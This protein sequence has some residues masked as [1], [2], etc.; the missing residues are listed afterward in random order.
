MEN[1]VSRLMFGI[2][3]AGLDVWT[4][5]S[6]AIMSLDIT[7]NEQFYLL[8]TDGKYL[9]TGHVFLHKTGHDDFN[10]W[11]DGGPDFVLVSGTDPASLLV[12]TVSHF[13]TH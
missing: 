8:I 10:L 13:Y 4:G 9:Q 11:E 1:G 6:G 5:M 12:R 7:G 3:R 2:R